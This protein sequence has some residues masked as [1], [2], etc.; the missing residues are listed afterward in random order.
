MVNVRTRNANLQS[1][2]DGWT[3]MVKDALLLPNP[4][5]ARKQAIVSFVRSFVPPDLD[6][7]DFEHFSGTLSTD[8][9]SE[10]SIIL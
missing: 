7:D 10:L 4:S 2:L 5:E 1:I 8:D 3:Q 9:V 6:G